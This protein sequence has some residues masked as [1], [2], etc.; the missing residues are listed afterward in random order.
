[1]RDVVA[2]SLSRRSLKKLSSGMLAMATAP[3]FAGGPRKECV[4]Q[5]RYR[6]RWRRW[7]A[8]VGRGRTTQRVAVRCESAWH[9]QSL[10]RAR[11]AFSDRSLQSRGIARSYLWTMVSAGLASRLDYD[12]KQGSELRVSS[13]AWHR[14]APAGA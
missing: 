3:S 14:V 6:R 4:E 8:A 1:M 7:S 2:T 10:P 5:G 12:H 13:Q 9:Q 11:A